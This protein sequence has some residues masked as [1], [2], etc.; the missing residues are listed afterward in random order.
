MRV[1]GC[2]DLCVYTHTNHGLVTYISSPQTHNPPSTVSH[3]KQHPPP[4]PQSTVSHN[5]HRS[6]PTPHH[7]P[8]RRT[9]TRSP[10]APSPAPST[11]SSATTWWSRPRPAT[12]YVA[13]VSVFHLVYTSS[14]LACVRPHQH[15]QT[16]THKQALTTSI[17]HIP[18]N[19]RTNTHTQVI[20]TGMMVVLGSHGI[21][22]RGDSVVGGGGG[23]RGE[24]GAEGVSGLKKLG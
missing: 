17:P 7:Q 10:P 15:T 22:G 1:G 9:P 12:R 24:G 19:L 11:S 20:F 23:G 4:N 16:R 21:P 14:Y 6:L 5:I 18:P 3:N 2:A 8:R 13:C